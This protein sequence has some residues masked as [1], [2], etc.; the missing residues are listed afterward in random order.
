LPISSVIITAA[1]LPASDF[2]QALP[3]K[4]EATAM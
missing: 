4:S 3:R 2:T 1:L